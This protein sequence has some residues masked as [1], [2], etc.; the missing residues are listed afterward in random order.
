MTRNPTRTG[1]GVLA[2]AALATAAIA[3]AFASSP[4]ASTAASKT[5]KGTFAIKAGKSKGSKASGSYFRMIQ[6]KGSLK[7]G[8][9]FPNPDSKVSNKS[10]TAIAPGKDGGIKLNKFQPD[11]SPAFDSKRNA[12]A[13]KITKPTSFT[14][15]KFSLTTAAKDPQTKASVPAPQIKLSGKK[16]SGQ[17]KA[18]SASWNGQHFNQ[19]SP[20]PNG[21]KPGLTKPVTGSYNAK[22]HKFVLE[23]ASTVVGGPFDGFT[24]FWHVEGTYRPSK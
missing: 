17:L 3:P 4:S 22:T 14:G 6:P 9:F 7:S 24:G 11:P 2:V 23:W 12:R 18:W 21:S 19:G 13:K 16:L 5:L 1:L 8:P 15:V 10:Y 20:K